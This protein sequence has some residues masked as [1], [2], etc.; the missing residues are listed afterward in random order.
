M[1]PVGLIIGNGFGKASSDQRVARFPAVAAPHTD[2]GYD[3]EIGRGPHIVDLNGSGKWIPGDDA[4]TF[5]PRHMVQ[6]TDKARYRNPS[7][8]ALVRH[9]LTLV[10]READGLWIRSGMPGAWYND[11]VARAEL[12]AAIRAAAAP[13]GTVTVK[14][15]P[16][17]AGVF[18]A[19]V[20]ESGSLDRTRMQG[21]V[22]VIDAG[23]RDVNVAYF[24]D[25]SYIAGDSVPG[26]MLDSLATIKRLIARDPELR[27]ELAL[28]EVDAAVRAGGVRVDGV[29][30]PLPSGTQE[31]L[32]KGVNAVLG[33]GR[34]LWP[35]GGRTLDA[36]V[37]GGGGAIPLGPALAGEFA[38]LVVPGADLRHVDRIAQAIAAADPQLSG[39]RGFAAIAAAELARQR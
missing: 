25:G 4:I 32:L 31:A 33:V 14:I 17:A 6:I 2:V 19:Y 13:W 29:Q 26:G 38:Q 15:A 21:H 9:A 3:G 36:L 18:F 10:A 20:F 16:E 8:V 12:E 27:L 1:Q 30:R 23:Y 39:A 5:A 7:F 35:N 24:K 37:L 11:L 28:H 22:G 34:S